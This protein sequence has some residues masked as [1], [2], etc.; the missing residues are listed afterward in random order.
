MNLDGTM[1]AEAGP[2]EGLT[3][4]EARIAVVDRLEQDG[5]LVKTENHEHSVGHCE[6]CGTVVEPLISMQW[7]V[8]MERAG[9]LRRSQRRR[10]ARFSSCP[11]GSR[12]S[13]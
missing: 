11:S 3:V 13:T 1:N 10:T 6:R 8:R 2:F 7:F 12:A 5:F 9:A 4:D